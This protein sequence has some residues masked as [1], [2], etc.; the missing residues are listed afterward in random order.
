MKQ[1][2]RRPDT[3]ELHRQEEIGSIA[4]QQPLARATARQALSACSLPPAI[5][6]FTMARCAKIAHRVVNR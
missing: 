4:R 6:V 3:Q 5:R 2:D 1:R